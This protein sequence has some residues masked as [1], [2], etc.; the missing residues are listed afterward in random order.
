MGCPGPAKTFLITVNPTGQVN[1]PGNQAV[2]H[3]AITPPIDFTTTNTGGTTTYAWTN[4]NT[5]IG[6]ES[7]GTGSIPSF[8]AINPTTGPVFA[9]IVVTPTFTGDGESCTGPPINFIITVNPVPSADP[10]SNKWV[11]ANMTTQ[12]I[13]F[14][15][16]V[17]GTLFTWTNSNPSIGLSASGTG[18]IP[19]FTSINPGTI[20][21]TATITVTPS[22][23]NAG[24]TCNGQQTVFTIIVNPI[25]TVGPVSDHVLCAGSA[26][27][28]VVFSGTPAGTFF[29]WINNNP[30]IGLGPNGTGNIPSFTAINQGNVPSVAGIGVLPMVTSGEVTCPGYATYFS[31]TVNPIPDVYPVS[32]QIVCQGS[33]IQ[34]IAFSG[35]LP[36]TIYSWTNSNPGIGLPGSGTGNIGP[37]VAANPTSAPIVATI[38][39]Q[40]SFG[41]GN[42]LCQGAG[43]TFTITVIPAPSVN[44]VTSQL[45]CAGTMTEPVIFTGS[46]PGTVYNWT[47]SNTQIGLA[48]SGTGDIVT[49]T[50][51]NNAA[52]PALATITVTPVYSS[53]TTGCSG[54]PGVFTIT[55]KPAPVPI[56]TGPT[57]SC[58]QNPYNDYLVDT[59]QNYQWTVSPGA[60]ITLGG[61]PQDAYA[62]ITWNTA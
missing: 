27:D 45:S 56:I 39:V 47:N 48:A 24:G 13:I 37:F 42:A 16:A 62:R 15:G 46:L 11:C 44:A 57:V 31:I 4:S 49:F 19:V 61:S 33:L 23:T 58:A 60:I 7:G 6:L 32:S 3:N 26:T 30:S 10:V 50:A 35:S 22:Y 20:P 41:G 43:T 40:P 25:P 54:S 29:N 9:T 28:P 14:S 18:N 36:G 51:V 8:T 34:G 1:Q 17:P 59:G 5:A 38:T 12:E 21:L 52:L 2:C 53:G 55:V